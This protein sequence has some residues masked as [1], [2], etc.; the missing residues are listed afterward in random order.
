MYNCS[1]SDG[2]TFLFIV[3]LLLGEVVCYFSQYF[4][5]CIIRVV[6]LV[7]SPLSHCITQYLWAQ[8]SR[9]LESN[10]VKQSREQ[11]AS[12]CCS[13]VVLC[14]PLLW[15]LLISQPSNLPAWTCPPPCSLCVSYF[16]VFIF[17]PALL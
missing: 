13:A 5:Y 15:L 2:Q 8:C 6:F 9:P 10:S 16:S 11:T 17:L 12:T 14:V 3:A 4:C 7:F 1:A